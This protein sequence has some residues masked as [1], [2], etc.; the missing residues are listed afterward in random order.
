MK[1]TKLLKSKWNSI[2]V[3]LKSIFSSKEKIPSVPRSQ[4]TRRKAEDI[5]FHDEQKHS[6]KEKRL[7]S[8]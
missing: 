8:E 5:F 4:P 1:I 7:C 3:E 2:V 6:R